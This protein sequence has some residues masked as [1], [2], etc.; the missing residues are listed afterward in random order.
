MMSSPNIHR[1]VLL[2]MLLVSRCFS[3]S[4]NSQM[5]SLETE[6]EATKNI[7]HEMLTS[8]NKLSKQSLVTKTELDNMKANIELQAAKIEDIS[9]KQRTGGAEN[10]ERRFQTMIQSINDSRDSITAVL[11]DALRSVDR[12]MEELQERLEKKVKQEEERGNFVSE[13]TFEL[14]A[15]QVEQLSRLPESLNTSMARSYSAM[16]AN[17]ERRTI[18]RQE[19]VSFQLSVARDT[20]G[21]KVSL[22]LRNI[23]Y[24]NAMLALFSSMRDCGW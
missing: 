12:K 8:V 3:L 23:S 20:S 21:T 2:E 17:L 1:I 11:E 7:V 4:T 5:S 18:T 15:R 10:I 9:R 24:I 6:L 19:F 13:E 16:E 22:S 14:M